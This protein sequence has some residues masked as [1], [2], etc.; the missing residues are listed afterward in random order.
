MIKFII[1]D[2]DGVLVEAKEIHYETLNSAISE[3]AGDQFIITQ[4][5]HLSI[6]DGLKT[7]QKLDMLTES[8]GLPVDNHKKIW[9]LKQKMTIDAI[10]EL[11]PNTELIKTFQELRKSGYQLACCSNSIRRTVLVVLSKLGIIEY[12]DLIIS[13]E[14]VGNSKPHPEMYWSAMSKM[15]YIP[16]ETL[17]VEDSPTGLLA[18]HRSNSHIFRV[19]NSTEVTYNKIIDKINQIKIINT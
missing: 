15:G 16:D 3:I 17:I 11:K 4:N 13:N 14:D 6:Y 8:K 18:A 5:E 19:K 1:F 2:L 9:D 7:N 10:S 12:L